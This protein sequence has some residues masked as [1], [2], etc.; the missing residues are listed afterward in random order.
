M[1]LVV[2]YD[3]CEANAV[4]VRIAPDVFRLDDIEDRVNL[5]VERP[6]EELRDK[7]EK[8]VKRCPKGALSIADE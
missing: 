4:C 5:L 3:L 6:G 8:A 2:N 1:K 7:L